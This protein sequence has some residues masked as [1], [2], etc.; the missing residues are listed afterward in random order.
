MI[1]CIYSH[2]Y[3]YKFT[4]FFSAIGTTRSSSSNR[5]FNLDETKSNLPFQEEA[6]T[7]GP[8]SKKKK[9]CVKNGFCFVPSYLHK[10]HSHPLDTFTLSSR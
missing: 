1:Y 7:A 2:L 8:F 9:Q 10:I 3:P 5:L 4:L 6:R